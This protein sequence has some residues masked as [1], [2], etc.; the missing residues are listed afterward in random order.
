MSLPEL[1]IPMPP[2]TFPLHVPEMV[3]PFIVHFAIALPFFIIL[4]ELVNLFAK[5]RTLGILSFVF[6]VILSGILYAAMLTGNADAEAAKA[7]LGADAK[8]LLAEHKQWGIY[9]FYASVVLMLIKLFSVMIRKTPMRVFFL[10]VL[11][12]Y[13]AAT[14]ATGKRGGDLVYTYG[15]NVGKKAGQSTVK[16][17]AAAEAKATE[18][19]PA[20]TAE[21]TEAKASEAEAVETKAPEAP[22]AA[23]SEEVKSGEASAEAP[24]A[25]KP[26]AE[27]PKA[28]EPAKEEE[29][30]AAEATAQEEK[31]EADAPTQP[32][33]AEEHSPEAPAH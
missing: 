5:K 3:H 23:P 21:A 32:A 7:A 19:K 28:E 33:P 12:L 31:A 9:L 20:P 22:V 10:I 11:F 25:E 24:A 29:S 13:A 18:E 27:T 2:A 1:P 4:F 30:K 14:L 6:M 16:K 8:A 26:E 15:V 17:P